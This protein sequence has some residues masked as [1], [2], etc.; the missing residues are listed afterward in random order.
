MSYYA[1]LQAELAD[2]FV[3]VNSGEKIGVTT[4]YEV[5]DQAA[6]RLEPGQFWLIGGHSG[7]GK[8]YF[9]I[10]M[11]D[12]ILQASDE[13]VIVFTTELSRKAYSIRHAL[14]RAGVWKRTF[15]NH[16]EQ[17]AGKVQKHLMD[18][19]ADMITGKR[20]GVYPVTSYE[21]IEEVIEATNPKIVFIDYLQELSIGGKFGAADTMSIISPKL[22][23]LALKKDITIIGVSQITNASTSDEI[24]LSGRA[25]FDYGKEAF[26]AA[27][28]SIWI[29]RK[30]NEFGKL[31]PKLTLGIIK[32]RDGEPGII[33]DMMIYPG[34]RIKH[35]P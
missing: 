31:E 7:V 27:H 3:Q 4:G 26:R 22:K 25:P 17:Y 10:N 33:K 21:E 16:A 30:M 5:I 32:A 8:S 9:V 12:N 28:C 24:D 19:T 6:G 1:D 15:E 35:E 13:L 23:E 14:M 29:K 11:V 18:Y 20:F 34:Y 2:Y